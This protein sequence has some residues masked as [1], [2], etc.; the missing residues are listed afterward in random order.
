MIQ[1][2][3]RYVIYGNIPVSFVGVTSLWSKPQ[4]FNSLR[5]KFYVDITIT[6]L[7]TIHRRVFHLKHNVSVTGFYRLLQVELIQLGP[8]ESQS[9]S[10]EIEM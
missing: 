10:P 8:I 7:D 2:P 9:L 5:M 3:R 4:Q 6:I 1:S